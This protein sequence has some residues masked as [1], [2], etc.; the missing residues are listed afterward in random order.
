MNK[1]EITTKAL[2]S[3][4]VGDCFQEMLSVWYVV[5]YIGSKGI[6]IYHEWGRADTEN[7]NSYKHFKN[8]KEFK[9]HISYGQI[10]GYWIDYYHHYDTVV[11]LTEEEAA[12]IIE[13]ITQEIYEGQ[14]KNMV[15]ETCKH[16]GKRSYS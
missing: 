11:P 10:P 5:E 16:C 3:L 6:L 14:I 7:G 2:K 4:K 8:V 13:R 12:K 9:R 1:R 15:S